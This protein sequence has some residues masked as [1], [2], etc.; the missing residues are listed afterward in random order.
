MPNG[1]EIHEPL[2]HALARPCALLRH[3]TFAAGRDGVIAA[4]RAQ[5]FALPAASAR[6]EAELAASAPAWVFLFG[7][8]MDDGYAMVVVPEAAIDEAARASAEVAERGSLDWSSHEHDPE[9]HRA[10]VH[11]LALAGLR[12]WR[13]VE[14]EAERLPDGLAFDAETFAGWAG[15]WASGY[16]AL[17]GARSGAGLDARITRVV[18]LFEHL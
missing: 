12:E 9:L 11:L 15:Q 10:H 17:A 8:S 1:A 5:G 3:G 7:A 18:H 16:D 14:H 4:L 13:D 2:D 6:T